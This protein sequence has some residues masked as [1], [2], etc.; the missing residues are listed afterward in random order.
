MRGGGRLA[1]EEE[2]TRGGTYYV[3][4]AL[5]VSL[6]DDE[7]YG[8]VAEGRASS[9][10]IVDDSFSVIEWET[11]TIND[12]SS[13]SS[14]VRTIFDGKTGNANHEMTEDEFSMIFRPK[15]FIVT[16][17]HRFYLP[18]LDY[19]DEV[20]GYVGAMELCIA[21]V[22]LLVYVL[23]ACCTRMAKKRKKKKGKSSST[24]DEDEPEIEIG[25]EIGEPVSLD[26]HGQLE[27]RKTKFEYQLGDEQL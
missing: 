4:N 18:L 13:G 19:I 17:I 23:T 9:Q 25:P 22:A 2:I 24:T 20:G 26:N 15:S 12:A 27:L 14:I 7:Y 21:L 16:E 6:Y 8:S 3:P 1:D 11:T 5:I 10:I